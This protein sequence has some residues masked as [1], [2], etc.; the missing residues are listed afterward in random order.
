MVYI[1]VLKVINSEC[2]IENKYFV[3]KK[4]K[5]G[6]LTHIISYDNDKDWE[7]K[8]PR[9]ENVITIYKYSKIN[10]KMATKTCNCLTQG[11]RK[12]CIGDFNCKQCGECLY[13]KGFEEE[14]KFCSN[15]CKWSAMNSPMNNATDY[16]FKIGMDGNLIDMDLNVDFDKLFVGFECR[17]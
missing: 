10:N 2:S 9:I 8:N 11:G 15:K 17:F 5:T 7:E 16:Y 3:D 4:I 13:W 12:S 14:T 6:G 1:K